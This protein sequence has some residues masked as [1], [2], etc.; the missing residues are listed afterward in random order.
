MNGSMLLSPLNE[1]SVDSRAF[2]FPTKEIVKV[3]VLGVGASDGG[4]R[5]KNGMFFLD[6]NEELEFRGLEILK[7]DLVSSLEADSSVI[8]VQ[9]GNLSLKEAVD[10]FSDPISSKLALKPSLTCEVIFSRR[11]P[12]AKDL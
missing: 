2:C 8:P 10:E 11:S 5:S 3:A 1:R 12:I 7:F 4:L 9:N 6:F